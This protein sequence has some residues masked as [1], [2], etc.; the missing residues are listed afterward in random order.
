MGND[1]EGTFTFAAIALRVTSSHRGRVF[2]F[3]ESPV[4]HRMH[5]AGERRRRAW[6][7]TLIGV[8]HARI[9]Y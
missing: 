7:Q 1:L 9:Q 5:L 6:L 8:G 3:R 4:Y 2:T